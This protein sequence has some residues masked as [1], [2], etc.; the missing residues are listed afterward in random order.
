VANAAQGRE[1]AASFELVRLGAFCDLAR[2]ERVDERL[3][4]IS[5]SIVEFAE[6]RGLRRGTL[7][8]VEVGAQRG[9]DESI[10][11][12]PEF[13][14]TDI[15][16]LQSRGHIE[17]NVF[18]AVLPDDDEDDDH[19]YPILAAQLQALGFSLTADD[20]RSVPYEVELSTRLLDALT[21]NDRTHQ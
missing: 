17:A 11:V 20:L 7:D 9:Y 8:R 19:P 3:V 2:V 5:F 4:A 1:K 10:R 16:R 13:D 14:T 21:H 12:T 15:W 6:L 18:T